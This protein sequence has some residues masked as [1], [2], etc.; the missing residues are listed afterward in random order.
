MSRR[1]RWQRPDVSQGRETDRDHVKQVDWR[2][3][4]RGK[5]QRHRKPRP[6][7]L[8][9][10]ER[11]VVEM[12]DADEKEIARIRAKRNAAGMRQLMKTMEETAQ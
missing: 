8:I 9:E 4:K 5:A 11:L 7:P 6:S 1:K 10:L 12:D 2:A 3:V